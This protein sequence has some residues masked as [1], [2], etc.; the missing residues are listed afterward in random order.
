MI[1]IRFYC[2]IKPTIKTV[3]PWLVRTTLSMVLYE[4]DVCI[5]LFKMISHKFNERGETN[6]EVCLPFT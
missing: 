5:K 2:D 6:W 4:I 1:C 3:V